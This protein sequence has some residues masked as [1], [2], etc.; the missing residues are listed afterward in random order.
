[1]NFQIIFYLKQNFSE[2]GYSI[3]I[4]QM[5]KGRLRKTKSGFKV[6]SK[7]QNQDTNLTSLLVHY[8]TL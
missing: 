1:M 6:T 3:S 5:K 4:L 7:R 8:C 2:G